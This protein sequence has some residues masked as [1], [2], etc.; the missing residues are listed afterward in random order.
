MSGGHFDYISYVNYHIEA[1]ND[2]YHKNKP[3]AIG[4]ER[5]REH[6]NQVRFFD[7][8]GETVWLPDKL[9]KS[10]NSSLIEGDLLKKGRYIS[11]YYRQ[12]ATG[13]YTDATLFVRQKLKEFKKK[14]F[15]CLANLFNSK[16]TR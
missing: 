2:K 4:F 15:K 10:L 13:K 5:D 12:I 9:Y 11:E 1:Y 3:Y 7:K 6:K 8:D 16:K 14:T